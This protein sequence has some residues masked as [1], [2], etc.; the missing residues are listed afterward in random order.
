MGTLNKNYYYWKIRANQ[1]SFNSCM[2]GKIWNKIIPIAYKLISW[3]YFGLAQAPNSALL[4]PALPFGHLLDRWTLVTFLCSPGLL[5]E[6]NKRTPKPGLLLI[7]N[8]RLE[9]LFRSRAVRVYDHNLV[10][11]LFLLVRATV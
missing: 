8:G 4:L 10:V 9:I 11:T 3:L 2:I 6:L 7:R 1:Y 5:T